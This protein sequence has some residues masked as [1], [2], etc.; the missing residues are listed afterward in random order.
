[1]SLELPEWVLSARVSSV[2]DW[3]LAAAPTPLLVDFF[4]AASKSTLNFSE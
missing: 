4:K 3:R 2:L 1:M